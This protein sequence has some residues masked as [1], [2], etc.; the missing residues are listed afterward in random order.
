MEEALVEHSETPSGTKSLLRL[1]QS[2]M[3]VKLSFSVSRTYLHFLSENQQNGSPS[4]WKNSKTRWFLFIFL[5]KKKQNTFYSNLGKKEE[6]VLVAIMNPFLE[7]VPLFP[8]PFRGRIFVALGDVQ[9]RPS[10]RRVPGDPSITWCELRVDHLIFGLTDQFWRPV[11]GWRSGVCRR[12]VGH[13]VVGGLDVDGAPP[14]WR[15][16]R[17][18]PCCRRCRGTWRSGTWCQGPCS[19]GDGPPTRDWSGGP[20]A[21]RH[22]NRNTLPSSLVNFRESDL[23]VAS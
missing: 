11:T 10:G 1:L 15:S 9:R 8:D 14:T 21:V 4:L 16:R 12:G 20:S 13:L 6:F 18:W 5:L 23:K 7:F 2:L 22:Q 17:W 19:P 3:E